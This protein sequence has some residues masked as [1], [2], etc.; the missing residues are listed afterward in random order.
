MNL[1]QRSERIRTRVNEARNARF[2]PSISFM[3]AGASREVNGD[4]ARL[5]KCPGRSFRLAPAD[6]IG[7]A[8]TR[9]H[10]AGFLEGGDEGI[11]RR[12]AFIGERLDSAC[13]E[14]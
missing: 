12:E 6:F 4:R 1:L 14:K 7:R 2:F 10:G 9:D 3:L 8:D 5:F 13:L 11:R